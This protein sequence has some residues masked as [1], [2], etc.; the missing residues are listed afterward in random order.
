M[1]RIEES[2][3]WA[4]ATATAVGMGMLFGCVSTLLVQAAWKWLC[5]QFTDAL[6]ELG[7]PVHGRSSVTDE[8]AIEAARR[9]VL[10]EV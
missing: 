6:E 9:R 3:A 8:D 1:L 7:D 5:R 10:S 2:G 4:M